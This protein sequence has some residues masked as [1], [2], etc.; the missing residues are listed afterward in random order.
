M[1]KARRIAEAD[2]ALHQR[3]RETP[4][5]IRINSIFRVHSKTHM[6]SRPGNG[7]T[8]SDHSLMITKPHD[9]LYGNI[10]SHFR[11]KASLSRRSVLSCTRRKVFS[12]F[13][14]IHHTA[15][16]AASAALTR[17]PLPNLERLYR[18]RHKDR[19][20]HFPAVSSLPCPQGGRYLCL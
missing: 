12:S 19:G 11:T 16:S 10:I 5:D 2:P 14:F 3:C 9:N 4:W 8:E 17:Y 13:W 18:M 6:E 20:N 15:L 1:T 7:V